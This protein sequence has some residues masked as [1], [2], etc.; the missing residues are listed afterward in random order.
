[1]REVISNRNDLAV[2]A[3]SLDAPT[4]LAMRVRSRLGAAFDRSVENDREIQT[5]FI[6][7]SSGNVESV[8][9]EC[10]ETT[11]AGSAAASA[12]KDRFRAAYNRLRSNL[13]LGASDP[14]F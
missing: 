10:L 8:S 2:E 12:A 11:K 3:R 13:G 7:G 5:C 1:M 9:A 6:R 4:P 14:S